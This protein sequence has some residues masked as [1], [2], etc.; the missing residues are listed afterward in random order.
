MFYKVFSYLLAFLI[1]RPNSCAREKLVQRDFPKYSDTKGDILKIN[2]G[3]LTWFKYSLD[4]PIPSFPLVRPSQF[5]FLS[6]FGRAQ[7]WITFLCGSITDCLHSNKLFGVSLCGLHLHLPP[8]PF[9]LF[10]FFFMVSQQKW[11]AYKDILK[12]GHE[13]I[14]IKRLTVQ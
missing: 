8:E 14:V 4:T 5:F 7:T 2:S 11:T 6:V 10:L 9:H 13:V 1:L 12:K 3:H